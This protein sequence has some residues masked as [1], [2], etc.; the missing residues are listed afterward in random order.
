MA[1]CLTVA[2][3]LQHLINVAFDDKLIEPKDRFDFLTQLFDLF[4]HLIPARVYLGGMLE[5]CQELV[6]VESQSR[7]ATK[8]S[9][10]SAV[11]LKS[12]NLPASGQLQ[13]GFATD[14]SGLKVQAN[15]IENLAFTAIGG[16][17]TLLEPAKWLPTT[18]T[19]EHWKTIGRDGTMPIS[20]MLKQEDQD[21]IDGVIAEKAR[22]AWTDDAVVEL[23]TADGGDF[24]LPLKQ[25]KNGRVLYSQQQP[26]LPY[27]PKGHRVTLKNWWSSEIGDGDYLQALNTEQRTPDSTA[28]NEDGQGVDGVSLPPGDPCRVQGTY[29]TYCQP[30]P[31]CA[32]DAAGASP[33]E[34]HLLWTF[35]YTGRM[36]R[37]GTRPFEEPLF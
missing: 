9:L 7:E 3:I 35:V 34:E 24:T 31:A 21:A 12:Q 1:N 36:I 11:S 14:G 5:I 32:P 29:Y 23:A 8:T 4:G 19:P 6:S 18:N 28:Q 2:P 27:F 10:D 15:C 22:E 17:P 20:Q 37:D 25:D 13:V 26:I 16:E 33:K 30:A